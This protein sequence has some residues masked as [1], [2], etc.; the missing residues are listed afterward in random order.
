LGVLSTAKPKW[1]AKKVSTAITLGDNTHTVWYASSEE[2]KGREADFLLAL[3]LL[4]AMA[5]GTRLSLPESVS[6]ELLSALPRIQDI[7]SSWESLFQRIIVDVREGSLRETP[8]A[9]HGHAV[10]CFFTGGVDSFYTAL[11]HRDEISHLIYVHGFDAY[12]DEHPQRERASH[13]V[14]EVAKQ[15]DKSLIEVETNLRSFSNPQVWWGYYH[16]TALISVAL[17]FQHL[18]RKVMVPASFPYA[19]LFPWGTHP[20]VDPLW[21]TELTEITHEGCEATR[22]EKAAY[23]AKHETAMKWLRVCPHHPLEDYNC[24]RCEKCLR[25]MM[26]LK[27]AGALELCDTLPHDLD[28]T[29]VKN[30]RLSGEHDIAFAL[31]NL[32]ALEKLGTEPALTRAVT[33]MIGKS[34]DTR[35]MKAKLNQSYAKLATMGKKSRALG[36]RKNALEARYKALAREMQDNKKQLARY[37]SRRRYKLADTVVDRALRIPLVKILLRRR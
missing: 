17:L 31:D 8:P 35:R 3:T 4:P 5:M 24:G 28:P 36:E 21:S 32:K 1:T 7:F 23:I 11:K 26:N 22:V 27:A 16:G 30:I 10:A 37:T 29:D 9:H 20:L 6:R 14:R 25:T 12:L 34:T 19:D 2:L 13:A 33:E 18:F 15:F